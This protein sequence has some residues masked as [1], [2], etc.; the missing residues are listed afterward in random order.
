MKFA[1]KKGGLTKATFFWTSGGLQ[2][3]FV[4]L[5]FIASVVLL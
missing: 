2:T 4:L 3:I 1:C 5:V